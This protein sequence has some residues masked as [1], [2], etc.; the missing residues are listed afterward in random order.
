[1][2]TKSS[3]GGRAT[4]AES[5]QLRR[6]FAEAEEHLRSL[7]ESK[8]ASDE[9]YQSANEE[10]LSANE[11]LQSTN[12]ELE[13]SKEELQS[14][15][16]ELNTVNDELHNRNIELDRVNSDL[17]NVLTSTSLPVVM[18]DRGLRIRRLTVASARVLKIV[19]SDLGRPLFRYSMGCRCAEPGRPHCE[20]NRD[21]RSKGTGGTG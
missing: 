10:I 19:P 11:E 8:E 6:K 21:A 4:R 7:V 5:T 16:E 12:E 2:T 17:N 13:T 14:A 20:R 3:N 9:E 18:V 1:L 15:N